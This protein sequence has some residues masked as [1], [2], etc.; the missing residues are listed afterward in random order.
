MIFVGHNSW[1]QIPKLT[2]HFKY[3]T[4]QSHLGYSILW[5]FFKPASTRSLFIAKLH[6]Y[7]VCI[8]HIEC[9]CSIYIL[10][11]CIIKSKKVH[12]GEVT[13]KLLLRGNIRLIFNAY[14][15]YLFIFKFCL[16]PQI[17]RTESDSLD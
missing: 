11:I 5:M 7:T 15:I 10:S 6:E 1:N 16:Y 17:S 13:I 3:I 2:H 12:A 14:T 8:L 4:F 9:K